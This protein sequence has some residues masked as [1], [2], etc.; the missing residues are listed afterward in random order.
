[1]GNAGIDPPRFR[2]WRKNTHSDLTPKLVLVSS[3][4]LE[5]VICRVG[6]QGLDGATCGAKKI[7]DLFAMCQSGDEMSAAQELRAEFS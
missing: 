1:M 4:R 7:W 5:D 3:R 2:C 6:V